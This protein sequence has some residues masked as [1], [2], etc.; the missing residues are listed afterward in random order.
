M[1]VRV[2]RAR[3][4]DL[5]DLLALFAELDRL[6]RDWRVF[7]PRPGVSDEVARKYREAVGRADAMVA[8]AEDGGKI[9]GMAYAEPQTPS[10]FSDERSLEVSGV[11]VREGRRREGIGRLLMQEAVRFAREKGLRWV[12]LHTFGP[13]KDAMEFWENLGFSQRVV[14]L[15]SQVDDL[16]RRLGVRS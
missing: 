11:I 10:R 5:P 12:T 13:N 1:T 8:V 6:Q 9:V 15:S 16:A 14:Q 3:A 7:T 2:R 4:E